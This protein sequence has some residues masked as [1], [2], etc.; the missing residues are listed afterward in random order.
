MVSVCVIALYVLV[1]IAGGV[2]EAVAASDPDDDL[3]TYA[4]THDYDNTNQ[5]PSFEEFPKRLLGTDWAGKSVFYK[6]LL[7][8]KV[9]LL[10]GLMANVIAIPLGMVLGAIAGYYGGW[11]DD[12]IVWLYTTLNSIPGIILLIALKFAF[13]DVTFL[14]L[15]LGGIHGL[16]I[17]LGIIGWVGSCRLVRAETMKIRE[18][19]YVQ[20][21]RATGTGGFMILFRHILPNVSHIGIINFSLGFVG[22]IRAEVTL[23]FLGLGVG[24]GVPSWGRM[25]NAARMDIQAGRLWELTSAVV[26]IFLLVLAL[27][28]F[29]DRLRDALDPRL[30]NV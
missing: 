15:D 14:G 19:D 24:A 26:A 28:I 29:G 8:A 18:L 27:S 6:T 17:A 16:Y 12:V 11:I 13:S 22:A 3:P 20:A 21:A 4:E 30:K 2:Y 9:S 1:A 10:I 23:S 25:I 7:G 5:P